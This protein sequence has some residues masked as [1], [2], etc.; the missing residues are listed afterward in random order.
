M[1]VTLINSPLY[2]VPAYNNVEYLASSTQTA[3]PNFVYYLKVTIDTAEEYIHRIPPDPNGNC[4]FNAIAYTRKFMENYYPFGEW[5]VQA[6]PGFRLITVNIGEEY[7]STPVI[8]PGTNHSFSTWNS[9]LTLKERSLYNP[10]NYMSLASDSEVKLMNRFPNTINVKM[11]QDLV[12][13]WIQWDVLFPTVTI[14]TYLSDGTLRDTITIDTDVITFPEYLN[15]NVGPESLNAF[16]TNAS[17]TR[18]TSGLLPWF[19]D[20]VAYYIV[21]IDGI[22]TYR[23]NIVEPCGKF[24]DYP[25]YYLQRHGAFDYVNMNANHKDVLNIEKKFY[26]GLSAQF[27]ASYENVALSTVVTGPNPLSINDKALNIS[28]EETLTLMSQPLDQSQ[29]DLIKDLMA[30]PYTFINVGHYD[31]VKYS[32]KN[33]QYE[34][35]RDIIEKIVQIEATLNAG[36]TEVRQIE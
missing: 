24:E 33:A 21:T 22:N 17:P 19:N 2:I 27:E 18:Y 32:C 20:S 28:Y 14:L 5:D 8:Y 35:K 11:D 26:K 25:L 12:L 34:L 4:Y 23:I 29:L 1:A 31:Y 30:S 13:S 3:Q 6:H 15:F 10:D 7:G 16:Q 36:V 9:S